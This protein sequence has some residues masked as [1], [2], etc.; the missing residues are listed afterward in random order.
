[1]KPGLYR[2]I[3]FPDYLADPAD[4][5]SLTSSLV[6]N[7]LST[8]PRKVWENTPRLNGNAVAKTS[9]R[10]DLG[11][12]AHGL[13][14]GVGGNLIVID[15]DSYR[16]KEAKAIRDQAYADGKTPVLRKDFERADA[17]ATA[18]LAEL[19][20]H[21]DIGPI[22]KEGIMREPTF[23]WR[24]AG[25]WCR[26]RPDLWDE[27][28]NTVIHYKTTGTELS[29]NTISGFAARSGWD[30]TAAHYEAGIMSH[31]GKAPRQL[32]AVQETEA[33]HMVLVIELGSVFMEVAKM[34]RKRA[35]TV[36]GRC[37]A[38]NIWPAWPTKTLIL[39][40]PEWHERQM[41][42]AKDA[43]RH[44]DVDL[45]DLCRRWQAP[46]G[47]QPPAGSDGEVLE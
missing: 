11:T 4:E 41:T 19:G 34:R 18:A 43:D 30:L 27:A 2:E 26:C 44:G 1:M 38:S 3:P 28:T 22:L 40:C 32:F 7:I 15:A 25:V 39:D 46:E 47:W 23:I 42:D 10:F 16:S 21:E 35:L 36:W 20:E 33:P 5:P 6:R 14:I 17:M 12:T 45:L 9:D 37:L 13:F 8:A 29:P 24:E 31:T